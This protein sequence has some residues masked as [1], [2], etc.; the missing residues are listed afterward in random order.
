MTMALEVGEALH[1][2]VG[3][4][5][6]VGQLDLRPPRLAEEE[7]RRLGHGARRTV[8]PW[9]SSLGPRG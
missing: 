7:Q 3:G 1:G 8:P 4:G 6:R 5:E 9:T 2:A